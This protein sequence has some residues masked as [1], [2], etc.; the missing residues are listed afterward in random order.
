MKSKWTVYIGILLS[1]LAII[2]AVTTPEV[3]RFFGFETNQSSKDAE[4]KEVDLSVQTES[5]QPLLSVNV[6]FKSQGAPATAL[7]DSNGYAK[8]KIPSTRDVQI[9]LRKE[10]F[11]TS[12]QIIDLEKNP[13]LT[14]TYMLKSISASTSQTPPDKPTPVPVS[15][16]PTESS[17]NPP[18][19]ISAKPPKVECKIFGNSIFSDG[20]YTEIIPVA[21][22]AEQSVSR[23]YVTRDNPRSIL[24]KIQKNFGELPLAYALPENSRL[25]SIVAKVYIDGKLRKNVDLNRGE[26][27]R[28]KIDI[29]GA[30]TYKVEF[31]LPDNSDKGDNIYVLEK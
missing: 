29:T 20:E 26:A 27:L 13:V 19:P 4:M 8:I 17:P 24:C 16:T 18:S 9:T 15:P 25:D 3:R 1:I 7:T 21:N 28:E 11:E 6:E 30:S 5:L 31:S 10:G 23:L 2:V 12:S 14:R 22:K